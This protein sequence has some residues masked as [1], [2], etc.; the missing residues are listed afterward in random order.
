MLRIALDSNHFPALLETGPA[1]THLKMFLSEKRNGNV[2]VIAPQVLTECLQA[3]DRISD[4]LLGVYQ[5]WCDGILGSD[6]MEIMTREL[7]G[8]AQETRPKE[9]RLRSISHVHLAK[10]PKNRASVSSFLARQREGYRQLEGMMP[11]LWN[12]L[13]KERTRDIPPFTQYAQKRRSDVFHAFLLYAA[14]K[15]HLDISGP[16]SDAELERRWESAPA[17]RLVSWHVIANEYR[18]IAKL[19]KKGQG[20]G[21]MTDVRMLFE[22]AYVDEFITRDT[23]LFE[24]WQMLADEEFIERPRVVLFPP[25]RRLSGVGPMS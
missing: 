11:Q 4:R 6:A 8:P 25:S 24:C 21:S 23:D 9:L 1:A 5:E 2:F 7:R 13:R 17:L 20:K 10:G 15:G 12:T 3:P 19:R 18:T 22:C 14:S 16:L